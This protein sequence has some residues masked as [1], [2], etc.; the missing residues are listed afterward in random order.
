MPLQA[1]GVLFQCN[2]TTK[3]RVKATNFLFKKVELFERGF[4]GFCCNSIA[5][6]T[7]G[8]EKGSNSLKVAELSARA[9][10]AALSQKKRKVDV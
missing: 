7:G 1:Y 8:Q 6:L 10:P 9:C 4:F 2:K 5:M 3:E